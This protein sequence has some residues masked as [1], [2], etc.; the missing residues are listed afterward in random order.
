VIES[1]QTN[2]GELSS[3]RKKQQRRERYA[4]LSPNTK[5]ESW[6]K[7]C[8]YQRSRLTHL[9]DEAGA[10]K[11]EQVR[12]KNREYQ[13][14]H[15]ARLKAEADA[16]KLEEARTKNHEYQHRR[17]ARLKAEAAASKLIASSES[18]PIHDLNLEIDEIDTRIDDEGN[19]CKRN[20]K[21]NSCKRKRDMTSQVD[22]I[23]ILLGFLLSTFGFCSSL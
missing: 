3:Q 21:G 8:E 5:E 10:S 22:N 16:S 6:A 7:K 2:V 12:A 20:N 1:S 15:L 13:R 19:S 18:T 17:R 11:L 14:S 23:G 9:K 4:A